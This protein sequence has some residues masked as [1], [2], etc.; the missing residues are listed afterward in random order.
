MYKIQ[1]I[2][3][4]SSTFIE[5]LD[6]PNR[7]L[8]EQE[9]ELLYLKNKQMGLAVLWLGLWQ[10]NQVIDTYDGQSWGREYEF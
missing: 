1:L 5:C 2:H 6:K 3:L 10:D 8:V 9:A 4:H 7:E